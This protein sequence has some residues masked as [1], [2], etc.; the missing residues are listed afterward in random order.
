MCPLIQGNFKLFRDV[1]NMG[2]NMKP[3]RTQRENIYFKNSV[4]SPVLTDQ[5]AF[6]LK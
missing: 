4:N 2:E 5:E 6:P 1:K 3:Q